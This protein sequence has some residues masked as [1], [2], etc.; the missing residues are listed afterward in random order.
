M[1]KL[2]DY[3]SCFPVIIVSADS[4]TERAQKLNGQ[5]YAIMDKPIDSNILAKTI[6]E[7][8]NS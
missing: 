8:L 7:A 6:K 5:A 2:K 3:K 4:M 1:S